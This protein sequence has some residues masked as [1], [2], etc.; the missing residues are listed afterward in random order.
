MF[1]CFRFFRRKELYNPSLNT[2]RLFVRCCLKNPI[3]PVNFKRDLGGKLFMP[4]K[5]LG[6]STLTLKSRRLY[7]PK[8][9]VDELDIS[10]GDLIGFFKDGD[11]IKVKKV[12][13]VPDK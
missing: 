9:V 10:D 2:F 13:V 11:D 3:N 5:Y 4:E 12:K 6:H 1:G 7:I 8:K